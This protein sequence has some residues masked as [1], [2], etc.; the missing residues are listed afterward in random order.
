M[1]FPLILD[2]RP[3]LE[4]AILVPQPQQNQANDNQR[5]HIQSMII[6]QRLPEILGRLPLQNVLKFPVSDLKGKI[7]F[8]EV[9]FFVV[10]VDE[11]G[12]LFGVDWEVVGF[13]ELFLR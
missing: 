8:E 4:A 12:D 10:D 2:L 5:R 9:S 6:N 7:Q 11:V 3:L 1:T 13:E